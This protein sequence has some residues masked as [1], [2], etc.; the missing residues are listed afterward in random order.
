M[1]LPPLPAD[2]W[3]D[4]VDEALSGMLPEERRNP[5]NAG[6]ILWRHSSA[7]PP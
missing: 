6:N 5:E 2:Q 3:D 1:R 7:T 4:A